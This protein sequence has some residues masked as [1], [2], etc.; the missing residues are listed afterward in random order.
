MGLW[1][2]DLL[3]VKTRLIYNG[4]DN[5]KWINLFHFL[6]KHKLTNKR[7]CRYIEVIQAIK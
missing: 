2:N 6:K 5:N 4:K 1:N 3:W 7:V